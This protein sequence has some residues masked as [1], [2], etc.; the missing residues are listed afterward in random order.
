VKIANY[1]LYPIDTG[2]FALDGGA[3]FGVV[4]KNLWEKTIPPD[5]SNRIPLALRS[6]LLETADKLILIDT[7]I[8][9]KFD[10]K[11]SKIY[12]IDFSDYSLENSLSA[13]GYSRTDIT[14]VIITHLHFDH[15]GGTT[16]VKNGSLE[17]TFPNATHHVQEEQWDW[18]LQPSQKD[19]ASFIKNDFH[20]LEE[21]KK[22]NKLPGPVELFSGIELLVMYGHTQGMQL[23]KISDS[24]HTLIYCADLIP[25]TSHIPV[26]WVMAYDN[27]PLITMNEKSRLL[28]QAAKEEWILFYEHDPSLQASTV[29]M[30]EKGYHMRDEIRL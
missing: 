30:T 29:S 2:R 10:E 17:L 27:N 9:T 16:F 8:G 11:Y 19:K 24:E 22:V 20:L 28:P 13:H 23:V 12:K 15:A 6:L 14:D 7:G 21:K 1:R 4:P 25:T 3:M 5:S 18:A 26:P